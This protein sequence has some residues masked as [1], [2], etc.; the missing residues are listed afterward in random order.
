MTIRMSPLI[1]MFPIA[2]LAASA[3]APEQSNASGSWPGDQTPKIVIRA[4]DQTFHGDSPATLRITVRD[5]T[6]LTL[7]V[8]GIAGAGEDA[9]SFGAQAR[10]SVEQAFAGTV[11]VPI[12]DDPRVSNGASVILAGKYAVHSVATSGSLSASFANGK[13]SGNIAAI[14]ANMS[15]DF[16]GDIAIECWVVD[17]TLA[18]ANGG[19]TDTPDPEFADTLIVRDENFVTEQCRQFASLQ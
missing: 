16:D 9:R 11:A 2:C 10:I 7:S 3:C 12:T 13:I 15:A 4:G 6:L 1:P 5:E 8:S 18:P 19:N 14:P 17:S